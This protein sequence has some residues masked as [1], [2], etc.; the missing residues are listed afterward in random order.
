MLTATPTAIT[1][2]S[3]LIVSLCLFSAFTSGRSLISK[4]RTFSIGDE[5]LNL[6]ELS[7]EGSIFSSSC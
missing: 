6:F 4:S 3:H 5:T 7:S 2:F 1:I